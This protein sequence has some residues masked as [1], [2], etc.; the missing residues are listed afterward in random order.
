MRSR[1]GY[2]VVALLAVLV[3]GGMAAH[4][5]TR[6]GDPVVSTVAVGV[7]PTDVVMDARTGR[8]FILNT[9]SNS[10]SMLDMRNGTLL[11]TTPVGRRPLAMTLDV[12]AGRVVVASGDSIVSVLD[13]L[14]GA[15]VRGVRGGSSPEEV[16]VDTRTGRTFITNNLS[17]SVS[18]LDTRSGRFLATI[19]V[20]GTPYA[21][22]VDERTSRVFV[23]SDSGRPGTVTAKLVSVIDSQSGRLLRTVTVG[24][25][26]SGLSGHI[27]V[28]ARTNRVFV[29][30][31]LGDSV[32]VLDA[33][34]GRVVRAIGGVAPLNVAVDERGGHVFVTNIGGG[35]V[36]MLDG[37]S[38]RLLR[39]V[40]VGQHPR[41]VA[42][43][44][45]TGRVFVT[46]IMNGTASVLDARSGAL[47]G[48]VGVGANPVDLAVDE[49]SGRVFIV[50]LGPTDS[51]G[52]LTGPGSVSALDARS[53]ALL[54]TVPVGVEPA[55][56][57]VD[58]Q[59]G[60]AI[61][62]NLA[63]NNRDALAPLRQVAP[64]LPEHAP[65]CNN[66]GRP[67]ANCR[68]ILGSV[69]VLDATR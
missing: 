42:V 63:G 41:L 61:V 25:D 40:R 31:P 19:P 24:H 9:L 20:S 44:G 50:S 10:V 49:R 6:T 37:A 60:R 43:D 56:V 11:R 62:V 22:A 21:V 4:R 26:R 1:Y 28:D 34:T 2:G 68:P 58:Q 15:I 27:A 57:V 38:G 65:A 47:L 55:R 23:K 48:A 16:A 67:V 36:S 3:S 54:Y 13:A 5:G 29:T 14:S 35:S 53:G 52:L 8:A 59:A 39:T 69:T 51:A 30:S 64:W 7:Q 66:Y 18:V 45:R 33:R 17:H 46:D 32:S 12:R